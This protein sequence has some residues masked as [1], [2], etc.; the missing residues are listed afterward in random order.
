MSG[1]LIAGGQVVDGTGAPGRVADVRIKDGRIAE[2][3]AGLA[4]GRAGIDAGGAI[5]A[6]GFINSHTHFDATIYWDPL[7][8]PMPQ[9]GVTTFVAGNCSLG[10]APMRPGRPAEPGRCLQLCRGHAGRLLNEAIPWDWESYPEYARSL[11]MPMGVNLVTL[12]GHSQLRCYVMGEAAWERARGRT[13]SPRWPRSSTRRL[14]RARPG[15]SYSLFD[16]DRAGRPVPS[17]LADD[18]EMDALVARL[19]AYGAALQ[20]VPGGTAEMLRATRSAGR[21]S[22]PAW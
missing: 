10:L 20:F 14:R 5:V 18:A 4:R 12:V 22:W 16:R 11:Q 17:C 21:P 9:H 3:G 13:R 1:L 2:I 19:G 6:P 7:L 8:D 15:M